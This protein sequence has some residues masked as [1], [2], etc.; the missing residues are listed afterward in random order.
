MQ[1]VKIISGVY[2]YRP[3]ESSRIKPV[4]AGDVIVVSDKEAARLLELRVAVP[5][6]NEPEKRKEI[7]SPVSSLEN[8]MG[9]ARPEKLEEIEN[10]S[11]L[12]ENLPNLTPEDPVI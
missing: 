4:R 1:Q 10:S 11:D 2:G 3:P 9:N 12:L 8:E 6:K 5:L 7:E